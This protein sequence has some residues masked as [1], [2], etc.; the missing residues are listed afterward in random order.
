MLQYFRI[1][2]VN[3]SYEDMAVYNT[4]MIY[5]GISKYIMYNQYTW[6]NVKG[7]VAS[8]KVILVIL[9]TVGTIVTENKV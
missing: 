3:V 7:T 9:H 1:Y 5:C 8:Q 6:N 4:E 2:N